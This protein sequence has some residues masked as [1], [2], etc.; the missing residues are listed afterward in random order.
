MKHKIKNC[1][2]IYAFIFTL[3]LCICSFYFFDVKVFEFS[4]PN[5]NIEIIKEYPEF[6]GANLKK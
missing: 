5:I 3:Y 2:I 1:L 4:W 6:E